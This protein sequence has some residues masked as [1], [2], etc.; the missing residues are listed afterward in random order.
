MIAGP[1]WPGVGEFSNQAASSRCGPGC[2][3]ASVP[4]GARPIGLTRV[5]TP[6]EGIEIV[7]GRDGPRG[8]DPPVG[9][10]V[11]VAEPR[12]VEPGGGSMR[13]ADRGSGALTWARI[14]MTTRTTA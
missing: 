11:G 6:I 4:S 5:L 9:S 2:G 14:T 10:G 12:V 7:V 3:T 8:A 13:P 1:G